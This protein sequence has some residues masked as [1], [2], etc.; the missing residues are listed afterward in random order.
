ML[1]I[2]NQEIFNKAWQAFIVEKRELSHDAGDCLY[3]G[4]DGQRCAIGLCIPDD[5]YHPEM[6]GLNVDELEESFDIR[7][8]NPEFAMTA[9][10]QLHDRYIEDTNIDNMREDYIDLAKE[11]GL[12]IPEG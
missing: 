6:E 8:E 9:Q 11:Y 7:F 2:T 5:Y 1:N 10:L 3:R 12:D 4:Y